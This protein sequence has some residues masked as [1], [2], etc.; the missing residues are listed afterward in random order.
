MRKS[1]SKLLATLLTVA[2]LAVCV[3]VSAF[4]KSSKPLSYLYTYRLNFDGYDTMS[5]SPDDTGYLTVP[6]LPDGY[7]YWMCNG[8][9]F[10]PG[11]QLTYDSLDD[12]M[13]PGV[14]LDDDLGHGRYI[15]SYFMPMTGE[16]VF[17]HYYTDTTAVKIDAVSVG[18]STEVPATADGKKVVEWANADKT[19]R[20]A[21]PNTVSYDDMFWHCNVDESDYNLNLYAIF[22]DD[23]TYTDP[24]QPAAPAA[25]PAASSED[26]TPVVDTRTVQQKEIDEAIANGTWGIEYTTCQKCGY[27]N[28]TRQGNVYVCDTCGNTTTT[29]VGP[30][31]VKGYVGSGAIAAVAPKASAPETRYSTAAEAQAAADKREAAYAA[32]VAAFQK[33]IDAQNAAYLAALGK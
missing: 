3:P 30:K 31:G 25:A 17:V 6:A 28:W 4:A 11:Q 7:A 21:V 8:R 18:G 32:A 15:S 2:A 1:A 19:I 14:D 10:T 24:T 9:H 20:I 23:A 22:E 16:T 27:H 33:Q 12:W 29:V 26:N 13:C 5:I